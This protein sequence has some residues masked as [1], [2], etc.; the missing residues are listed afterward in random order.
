MLL[1]PWLLLAGVGLVFLLPLAMHAVR[2][3][4]AAP[5]ATPAVTTVT[6]AAPAP[7]A[8][9]EFVP[10]P[11]KP[12]DVFEF[13][14]QERPA[15]GTV[16][17]D[18]DPAAAGRLLAGEGS[19]SRAQSHASGPSGQA[20]QP[21]AMR[22]FPVLGKYETTF[23]PDEGACVLAAQKL[24]SPA[25]NRRLVFL[26]LQV[27]I[28]GRS[29]Q[30]SKQYSIKL[31]RR[32]LYRIYAV[33]PEGTPTQLRSGVSYQVLTPDG[34]TF[35]VKWTD[36]VL[37]PERP[38]SANVRFLIG[39]PDPKDP[40]HLIVPF[41]TAAGVSGTLDVHLTDDDYLRVVPSAGKTEGENWYLTGEPTAE[42]GDPQS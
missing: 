21:P 14:R 38:A 2:S 41:A 34:D 9:P 8:R 32:L 27:Q 29:D 28:A 19:Y 6:V 16:V 24:T 5:V 13:Y 12:P 36:G 7:V 22:F 35:P 33:R 31:D 39:R 30:R 10:P 23:R 37:K 15:P 4:R 40:S 1:I 3:M 11:P 18:E 42:A 25:G 26:Y 20:F 17:Y